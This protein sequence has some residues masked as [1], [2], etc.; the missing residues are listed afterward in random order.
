[1]ERAVK[2]ICKSVIGGWQ[3]A[4][5]YRDVEICFGPVFNSATD[6]WNWQAENLP[7]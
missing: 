2:F 4:L 5:V 7:H 1:M 6:L 3:T